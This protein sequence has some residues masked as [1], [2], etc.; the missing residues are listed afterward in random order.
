[1]LNPR[2]APIAVALCLLLVDRAVGGGSLRGLATTGSAT[3]TCKSIIAV[4]PAYLPDGD[5]D[6]IDDDG[7]VEISYGD[8]TTDASYVE[9]FECELEDGTSIPIEMTDGQQRTLQELLNR[10]AL[11]SCETTIEVTSAAPLSGVAAL[12]GEQTSVTLPPGP[13]VLGEKSNDETTVEDIERRNRRLNSDDT[14][15]KM[16]VVRVIDKKGRQVSGD[17]RTQSD[18]WFGTYG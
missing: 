16:L 13:P 5:V 4:A 2:V 7:D 8:A 6:Y 9:T 3:Q 14:E 10:G 11:K 17:H 12:T 15:K 1:M 18:K